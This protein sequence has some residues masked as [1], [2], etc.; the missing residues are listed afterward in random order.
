MD[1]NDFPH[2]LILSPPPQRSTHSL[3]AEI[4]YKERRLKLLGRDPGQLADHSKFAALGSE[5]TTKEELIEDVRRLRDQLLVKRQQEEDARIHAEGMKWLKEHESPTLPLHA[6]PDPNPASS[7]P[8]NSTHLTPLTS[9]TLAPP[10]EPEINRFDY[11][12]PANNPVPDSDTRLSEDSWSIPDEDLFNFYDNSLDSIPDMNPSLQD[13]SGSTSSPEQIASVASLDTSTNNR[14]RPR[15]SLSSPVDH[16]SKSMRPS[17]SPALTRSTSHSS[18]DFDFR[19]LADNEELRRLVGGDIREDMREIR[20]DQKLQERALRQ[21]KEQ[22][23]NDAKL[24]RELELSLQGNDDLEPTWASSQAGPSN[25]PQNNSQATLDSNGRFC[26]PPL[27]S[28]P[29]PPPLFSSS[30]YKSIHPFKKE[31]RLSIF[32]S[33]SRAKDQKPFAPAR[34]AAIP[35][36]VDF[37][38]L[39]SDDDEDVVF[40]TAWPNGIRPQPKRELPWLKDEGTTYSNSGLSGIPPYQNQPSIYNSLTSPIANTW[41]TMQNA[42]QSVYNAGQA[43]FNPYASGAGLDTYAGIGTGSDPITLADSDFYPGMSG[44]SIADNALTARGL[45]PYN[46]ANQGL[47]DRYRE[48]VD[49]LVHDPTRT[50]AEIKSL[51]EN[52]RPDE[53]L[54][55]K[56]RE[57]TPEA[58]KYGLMNHQ[59]LGLAWMR[60]MEEGSNKGGILADDMGLGKTIQALALMVSRRSTNPARKTTLIVAPVALLK[61][62]EKEIRTKLKP[63]LVGLSGRFSLPRCVLLNIVAHYARKC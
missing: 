37:V 25:L 46:P 33:P 50:T 38:D 53:D 14:K 36:N 21:K 61:Q 41:S 56:D 59:M 19:D 1:A 44:I 39:A 51:L 55:E 7:P 40:N 13:S 35:N 5:A 12:E 31:D 9:A 27:T 4:D 58:M 17:P 16:V 60:K 15:E 6:R 43:V 52:I 22:E 42:A 8:A 32:D 45:N 20:R 57:G 11:L 26:L 10:T 3:Q 47:V 34:P 23:E 48:R 30:P 62:W 28:S 24:A 2:P 29:P 18:L 54:P 49:Y 63:G